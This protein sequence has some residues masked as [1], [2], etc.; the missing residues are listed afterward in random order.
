MSR[1]RVE[2]GTDDMGTLQIEWDN[3]TQLTAPEYFEVEDMNGGLHFGSLQPGPG[4]GTL[5]VVAAYGND[6]LP[7]RQVARIQLVKSSFWSRFRG[8]VDIGASYT[9]ATE[10]LRSWR[11]M[12][13]CAT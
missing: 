8:S 9:S 1:S 13:T 2:L 4:E 6:V 12:A 5:E 3:V 11:A 10:L 7:L